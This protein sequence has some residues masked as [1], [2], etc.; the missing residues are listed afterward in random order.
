MMLLSQY[1]LISTFATIA[2]ANFFGY[3]VFLPSLGATTP[4]AGNPQQFDVYWNVPSFLCHKY[5]VKFE[6]LKNFGIRQNAND[7]FRGEEIAILYDPGMFPALLTD[8]NGIVKKR[9]GGVPQEGDLNK[10]LEIFRK[11]LIQQIPDESFNGVGV[12]DFESWRPIFRQNWA[13][14]EPY[15]SLSIKLEREKHPIWSDAAIKKEAKRRFE[16]Y[17]R[18]FMEETLKTAKKLRPN[19]TL[20]YYGYPHCFNHTPGQRDAHCNRQTMVENDEISW[21]FTLEDVH[22]PSLYLRQ[23]IKKVDRVGFVKGRVS[24]ALRIAEKNSRKQRV[25]PYHWFKYQDHRDNFL[26]KEDTKNTINII[27]NLGADG[28]IIWGSSEDTNSEEKCKDLQQYVKD[29][30]GP[31]IKRI[32]QQ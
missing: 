4:E 23:E 1:L 11:H 2:T 6:D 9:N 3:L 5:G 20:G 24:E 7:K 28:I 31:A 27:A 30:L 19:A 12:I 25:L 22:M 21:L 10:H 14:L 16:K 29:V 13:S 15:K 18:I 17:G 32:K 8:K 26:T